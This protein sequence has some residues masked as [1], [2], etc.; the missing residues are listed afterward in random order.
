[1]TALLALTE[2]AH[3][4]SNGLLYVTEKLRL[5]PHGATSLVVRVVVTSPGTKNMTAEVSGYAS[6]SCLG[7]GG[8]GGG[9]SGAS[10]A[11][12]NSSLVASVLRAAAVAVRPEGLNV[13]VSSA[14]D[15]RFEFVA[16]P[17]GRAELVF[18]VRA[19]A[20][21]HVAL[22]DVRY[23]SDRMYQV[24]LGDLDN[25]VSWIGR[26]KHGY[27]V[28]LATT[29]SPHVL[30]ASAFRAFWVRWSGGA[31]SVGRGAQPGLRTLLSWRLDRKLR[32]QHVGFASAFGRAAEF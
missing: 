8:G 18:E 28:H 20:S 21:A 4:Q 1:V 30:S 15:F 12:A 25:S 10:G 24:V 14:E 19:A 29:S 7:G 3:F 13:V 22:S 2:G 26:G 16:A 31:V 17:R 23:T 6:D 32:V 5:G 11:A 27:G 9:G